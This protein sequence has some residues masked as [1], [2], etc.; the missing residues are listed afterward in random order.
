MKTR[1]NCRGWASKKYYEI[2]FQD[3]SKKA[4]RELGKKF[5]SRG[6]YNKRNE[7]IIFE[8]AH[9]RR[10]LGEI[11]SIAGIKEEDLPEAGYVNF[12]SAEL[13]VERL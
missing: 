9:D 3:V 2:A 7:N 12:G 6:Y 4:L 13:S 11:C 1:Q 10:I 5:S 8:I